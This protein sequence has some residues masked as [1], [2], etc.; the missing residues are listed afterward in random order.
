MMLDNIRGAIEVIDL[1]QAPS[2]SL[3]IDIDPS[4]P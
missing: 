3:I 1:L 2:F 4:A